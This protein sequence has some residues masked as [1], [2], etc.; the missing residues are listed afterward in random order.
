[1]LK[2]QAMPVPAVIV[3]VYTMDGGDAKNKIVAGVEKREGT[4]PARR[5]KVVLQEEHC[6][7]FK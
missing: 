2:Q 1:V 7:F 4:Y 3:P 5:C 6:I